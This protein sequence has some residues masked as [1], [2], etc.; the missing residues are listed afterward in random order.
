M[1]CFS[2]L[3]SA[4]NEQCQQFISAN[5]S[6]VINRSNF[7]QIFSCAWTIAMTPANVVAGFRATAIY[8]LNRY[9]VLRHISNDMSSNKCEM[10][11]L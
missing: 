7:T 5:P 6:Q 3:K 9:A 1:T 11:E 8:P 2:S 10:S 4:Y